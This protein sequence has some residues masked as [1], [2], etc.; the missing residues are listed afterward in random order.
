MMHHRYKERKHS[1]AC[2][3]DHDIK[4]LLITSTISLR[5]KLLGVL[6]GLV[7]LDAPQLV[8]HVF[9]DRVIRVLVLCT[10]I[11]V[12][13][14]VF[15]VDGPGPAGSTVALDII[16]GTSVRIGIAIRRL[17]KRA[18]VADG[19]SARRAACKAGRPTTAQGLPA[20]AGEDIVKVV[21][22]S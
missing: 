13:V 17:A 18:L 2:D 10:A 21:C 16:V 8:L 3:L 7:G 11:R 22:S 15:L 9:V 5:S 6:L 12:I 1:R 20:L 4:L 14:A 19:A